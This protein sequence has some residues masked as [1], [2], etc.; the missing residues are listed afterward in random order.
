MGNAP[1]KPKPTRAHSKRSLARSRASGDM[2]TSLSLHCRRASSWSRVPA[3]DECN[4]AKF[5]YKR[6]F[7]H[8]AGYRISGEKPLALTASCCRWLRVEHISGHQ[9]RLSYESRRLP[10]DQGRGDLPSS[11]G[12]LL[13]FGDPGRPPGSSIGR[14][15]GSS[16]G[17]IQ[18][19]L[20]EFRGEQ[21]SIPTCP[22]IRDRAPIMISTG[23]TR[24]S[25]PF[26]RTQP[27]AGTG[28]RLPS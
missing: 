23:N 20:A 9:G 22:A 27:R 25:R 7:H 6:A 1:T 28:P 14:P 24:S 13:V 26:R 21:F 16:F 8:P 12:W 5:I 17:A 11:P 3:H 2:E 10:P 15:K 4:P 18:P 19:A